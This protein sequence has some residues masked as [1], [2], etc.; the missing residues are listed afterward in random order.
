MKQ[1]TDLHAWQRARQ[2]LPSSTTLGFVPT[3]GHLHQGHASLFKQSLK[4]TD[5]T[6]VSLFINPTQFNHP[7]DF[8]HYPRTL[9][10]DLQQLEALGV[11]HC[12]LP[13]VEALYPDNYRYQLEEKEESL[14]LEGAHRSGHFTGVLTVVMKLFQLVRPTRAYFGEKD[15]QQLQLIRGMVDAFFMN[16]DIVACPIIRESSGLAC[17]SRNTRLSPTERE[18]ADHFAKLF[19]QADCTDDALIEQLTTAAIRVDYLTTLGTRR[20]AAV[21]VGEVRLIDNYAVEQ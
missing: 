8:K 15:Y 4:E 9:E 16:I 2:A 11:Q 10:Q 13:T 17:S 7:D 20:F 18:R 14:L 19:H 12:I 3:M 6:V 1:Y 5:Q 21:H